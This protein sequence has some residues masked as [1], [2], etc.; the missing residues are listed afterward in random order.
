MT[1]DIPLRPIPPF[2][3]KPIPIKTLPEWIDTE[4]SPLQEMDISVSVFD[5]FYLVYNKTI[6]YSKW[7]MFILRLAIELIIFIQSL[8]RQKNVG[9]PES[10]RGGGDGL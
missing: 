10:N 8:R 7:A 2:K 5:R 6:T 9:R 3:T 1:D 4:T